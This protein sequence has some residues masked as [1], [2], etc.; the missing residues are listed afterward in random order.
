MCRHPFNHGFHN[1]VSNLLII[2]APYMELVYAII[3]LTALGISLGSLVTI[4][5]CSYDPIFAREKVRLPRFR[6]REYESLAPHEDNA[7]GV[8]HDKLI[9]IPEEF[10]GWR[11]LMGVLLG[12]VL[13][14]LVIVHTLILITNGSSLLRIVF[15]VYWVSSFDLKLMVGCRTSL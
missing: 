11:L 1:S 12:T 5:L 3:L 15:I 4:R 7:N 9:V 2:D 14:A 13:L 8:S 6:N 10:K